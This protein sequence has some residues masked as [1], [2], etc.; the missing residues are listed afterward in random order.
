VKEAFAAYLSYRVKTCHRD[1]LF[2]RCL[3]LQTP[4]LSPSGQAAV[5]GPRQHCVDLLAMESVWLSYVLQLCSL[6]TLGFV[7]K[8]LQRASAG[9][10]PGFP[11]S[12]CYQGSWWAAS[13]LPAPWTVVAETRSLPVEHL[14]QPATFPWWRR[15]PAV[16]EVNPSGRLQI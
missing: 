7:C 12:C 15:L 2:L 9:Y 14:I 10:T 5:V 13:S 11:L 6:E 3:R 1:W 4:G 8:L 16:S